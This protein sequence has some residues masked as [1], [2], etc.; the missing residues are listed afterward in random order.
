MIDVATASV[1]TFNDKC[2]WVAWSYVAAPTFTLADG[3]G[4]LGVNMVST[5]WEI[6]AMEYTTGAASAD[7]ASLGYLSQNG[8]VDGYVTSSVALQ[9]STFVPLFNM[10]A[11]QFATLRTWYGSGGA[12]L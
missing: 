1:L 11:A 5:N 9:Q 4:A 12:T 6:H 10:P 8:A 7:L 3:A 2:T